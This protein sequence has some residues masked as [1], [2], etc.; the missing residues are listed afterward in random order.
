MQ[1]VYE[2]QGRAADGEAMLE[3]AAGRM[4]KPVSD[5]EELLA[6]RREW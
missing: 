1:F 4:G 5:F 6:K 2:G 3:A